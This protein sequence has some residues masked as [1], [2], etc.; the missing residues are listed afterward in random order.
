MNYVLYTLANAT[1]RLFIW[2]N[3]VAMVLSITPTATQ[4]TQDVHFLYKAAKEM[5]SQLPTAPDE[6]QK[7]LDN[8][9]DK[10]FIF[11]N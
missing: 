2:R 6:R 10:V 9:L 7:L 3:C 11:S 1:L 5:E 8:I 4:D